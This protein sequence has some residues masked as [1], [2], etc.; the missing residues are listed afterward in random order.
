MLWNV[1]EKSRVVN[2]QSTSSVRGRTEHPGSE[3]LG[4]SSS[5]FIKY[6][7]SLRASGLV[8][9]LRWCM[10]ATVSWEAG[11]QSLMQDLRYGLRVLAKT[12]GFTAVAVLT[13]AL[14]IGANTAIFSI[15]NTVLLR[16]LPFQ[17]SEQ[18]VSLG[19]FDTRR[20]PAISQSPVSYP[21]AMD[22]RARN[23]S[24][25]EVSVYSDNDATLTGIGEPLHV[26]VENV[27][28]SIFRLL[29]TQPAVGRAFLDSEDT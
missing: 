10:P 22:V 14:G 3:R 26:N 7:Q 9:E 19:N 27:S 12:P 5:P 28:A 16:P 17:N 2:R 8:E 4:H 29:G 1:V 24:F 18:L 11:M 23:H 6:Y 21:D 13:L 25:Q 20:T 15:V